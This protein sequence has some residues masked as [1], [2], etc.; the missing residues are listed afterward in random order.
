MAQPSFVDAPLKELEVIIDKGISSPGSY[1]FNGLQY[2]LDVATSSYQGHYINFYVNVHRSSDFYKGGLTFPNPYPTAGNRTS[3]FYGDRSPGF[4]GTIGGVDVGDILGNIPFD[5]PYGFDPSQGFQKGFYQRVA[6]A[7]SIYIPDTMQTQQSIQWENSSLQQMGENFVRGVASTGGNTSGKDSF[8][9]KTLN[10][11]RNVAASAGGAIGGAIGTAG[12][13]GGFAINPQL[14]V[15]FR[16]IDPRQF[17]Y[18]FYFTPKNEKEAEAVRNI[19]YAFRFH[20]HPDVNEGYGAFFVAPSTFDIEFNF[21][22]KRNENIH[23]VKTCVLTNYSVDYAPYG[24]STY[25][26]GMPIQ[27]RLVLNFQETDIITRKNVTEGY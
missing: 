20:S 9:N 1:D 7:I 27:T 4:G 18:E 17:T 14:L 5:L 25:T 23:Q 6:Q 26:D 13:I 11:I 15:L 10:S 16:G 24:W 8:M 2:P 21:R 22:G 12:R 19:I 3:G